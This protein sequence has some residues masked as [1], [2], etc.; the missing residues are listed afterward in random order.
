MRRD[1]YATSPEGTDDTPTF[2]TTLFP[3]PQERPLAIREFL[4]TER[5]RERLLQHGASALSDAELLAIITG[6]PCLET[7]QRLLIVAG[8][9]R[10][11]RIISTAELQR[12]VTGVS[13]GR[14]V[15]LKAAIELGIRVLAGEVLER[16]QIKSLRDVA[17][18]LMLEMSHLDQEQLRTVLLDTKNRVQ[19]ISTVY[20]GSL[21]TSMVRVGEIFKEALKLQ[22]A[23]QLGRAMTI[24]TTGLGL[25]AGLDDQETDFFSPLA[26]AL[27]ELRDVSLIEELT[28]QHVRLHPLVHEF[29]AGLIPGSEREK[30]HDL[31]ANNLMKA[32]QNRVHRAN[33]AIVAGDVLLALE[34]KDTAKQR[35][36]IAVLY[37]LRELMRDT[38]VPILTRRNAAFRLTRMDWLIDVR[39]I[40]PDEMLDYTDLTARHI[41]SS[42]NRT[43]M[44]QGISALLES[45]VTDLSDRQHAQ[46]LVIRAAIRGQ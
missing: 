35:I 33:W 30:F 24:P 23:G 45:Q 26:L 29:A 42:K 7:A 36:R 20:I 44:V 27:Q 38:Q 3:L 41:S 15:Q 21:N 9:L 8:G 31:L 46:L 11:L 1:D 10:C 13:V 34:W 2:Q 22:V 25:L 28:E 16:R 5:P 32:L 4:T 18:L 19:A 40:S 12:L 6:I 17:E 14:A 43:Y 39:D 37:A